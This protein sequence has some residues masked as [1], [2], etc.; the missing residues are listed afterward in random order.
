MTYFTYLAKP[1]ESLL[2]DIAVIQALQRDS[3]DDFGSFRTFW[4]ILNS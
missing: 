4:S 2:A 1:I 3:Y